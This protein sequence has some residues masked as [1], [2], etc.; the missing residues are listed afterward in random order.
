MRE[1]LCEMP[2]PWERLTP[3]IVENSSRPAGMVSI[4]SLKHFLCCLH[5][6]LT[7]LGLP[8]LMIFAYKCLIVLSTG[9]HL[10]RRFFCYLQLTILSGLWFASNL[11]FAKEGCFQ[12][13]HWRNRRQIDSKTWSSQIKWYFISRYLKLLIGKGRKKSSR[14]WK[15]HLLCDFTLST[16]IYARDSALIVVGFWQC[17]L[18]FPRSPSNLHS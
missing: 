11:I 12:K 8:E 16:F 4:F 5:A 3:N 2:N 1:R 17:T 15:S 6:C 13:V 9:A 7:L 18:A 14:G 10:L